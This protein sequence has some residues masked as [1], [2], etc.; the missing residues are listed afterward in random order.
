MYEETGRRDAL[1][2]LAFAWLDKHP[3]TPPDAPLLV[4]GDAGP[5]NF[6]FADG[7]LTAL[8]DWELAHPGDP[9]EDLAWFSMRSAMGPVPDFAERP[10]E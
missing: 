3:P 7:H 6:L 8:L 9:T 5:G 2:D 1:I 4:H 10:A